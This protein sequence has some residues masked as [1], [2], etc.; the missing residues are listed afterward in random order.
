M[1]GG[2][3]GLRGFALLPNNNENHT[4]EHGWLRRHEHHRNGW[5]LDSASHTQPAEWQF[6]LRHVH[7]MSGEIRELSGGKATQGQQHRVVCP[8][9]FG[10][11]L[12]GAHHTDFT[13]VH[14]LS[15]VPTLLPG[16]LNTQPHAM[17]I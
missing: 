8:G 17:G 9:C 3:A 16:A 13:V 15:N 6:W 2:V 10:T 5:E 12:E 14:E 4:Y 11:R 7:Q 1:T